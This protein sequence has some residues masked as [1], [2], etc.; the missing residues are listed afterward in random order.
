MDFADFFTEDICFDAL[1]TE[2]RKRDLCAET[3]AVLCNWILQ[4]F[5]VN[6]QHFTQLDSKKEEEKVFIYYRYQ[7]PFTY[8]VSMFFYWPTHPLCKHDLCTDKNKQMLPFSEPTQ[9]NAYLRNIWMVPRQNFRNGETY[10][11]I[12]GIWH[13]Y[14]FDY[15][16]R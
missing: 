8:Y 14:Y 5:K 2:S 10:F 6:F 3:V 12:L 13:M 4:N 11:A 9:F 15:C 16:C 7:G 1:D